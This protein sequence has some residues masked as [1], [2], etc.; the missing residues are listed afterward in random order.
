MEIWFRSVLY[1]F[2]V[3]VITIAHAIALLVAILLPY[4]L[5]FR[6]VMSYAQ[7][8]LK[9]LELSC[10]LQ[11]RV[12]GRE[13]IPTEP[14]VILCKHQSAWETL[15]LTLIFPL[16]TWVAKREL[17]WLP[18]FGWALW[19]LKPIL[20]DRS[21]RTKASRQLLQQGAERVRD[22]L[23][24]V[25]FPE[26][27]RVAAGRRGRYKAGGARLATALNLPIVPVAVNSG[28]FWPRNSFRKYSGQATMVIGPAIYPQGRSGEELTQLAEKWIEAEMDVISGVGPCWP[29]KMEPLAPRVIEEQ[30]AQ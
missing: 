18:F 16:Q 17:V 4:R 27:T 28:E 12:L 14:C 26:G 20:I 19:S 30:V 15:M 21:N 5:R 11:G 3:A 8:C 25:V 1:Q 23:S 7:A 2:G 24:I 13:N 29:G 22:G 10:G 9:W 6:L